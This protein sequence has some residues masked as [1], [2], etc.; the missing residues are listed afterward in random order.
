[1]I[2]NLTLAHIARQIMGIRQSKNIDIRYV[3][4]F[5]ESNFDLL[6]KFGQGVIPGISRHDILT[7]QFPFPPLTE[8]H[9]IVERV[10]ALMKEIDKLEKTEKELEAIKAAF[11]ADMKASLLQ[12]AM[13]G[14]LT[15]QKAEDGDARDLLREIRAEK[16]KLVKEKKIKKEKPLAPVS[17]DEIPFDIPDN[18]VW[19]RLGN[20]AVMEAGGTPARSHPEYWNGDI[21]WV[22]IGDM[23]KE[24]TDQTSEYITKQGIDHSSATIFPKGTILYSIF[25]SIGTV[26]ILKID[27]ATNQAIVGINHSKNIDKKY[28]FYILIGLRDVVIKQQHG[29]AQMNINQTILKNSLIPLPPI[30]EQRRVVEKLDK[31]LPLCDSLSKH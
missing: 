20:I 2:C 29:M 15:E 30:A 26:S 13:E 19:C 16:E 9:R 31:L 28:L 21:P 17:D 27:A 11:P 12:A 14:K 23:N 18:W 24:F 3:K 25:A 4:C 22:K 1:M 6:K 5:L 10:D 8:Q 7:M